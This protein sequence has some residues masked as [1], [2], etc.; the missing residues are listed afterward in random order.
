[1]RRLRDV[2]AGPRD[3]RLA[4]QAA[5]WFWSEFAFNDAPLDVLEMMQAA[6]QAGYAKALD[7]VRTG[8]L[9]RELATWRPDLAVG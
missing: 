7:D 5:S 8:T 9:D 4:E 6:V 2:A 3:A 1:M